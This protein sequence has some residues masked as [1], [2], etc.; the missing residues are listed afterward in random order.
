MKAL[1]VTSFTATYQLR[2]NEK[3]IITKYVSDLEFVKLYFAYC[4]EQNA[5]N[6]F[7]DPLIHTVPNYEISCITDNIYNIS[8]ENTAIM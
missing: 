1:M 5:T 2:T 3:I 6:T 4:L 7:K 8:W